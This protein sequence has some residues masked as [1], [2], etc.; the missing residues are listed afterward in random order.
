MEEL[1][2]AATD[3]K[4]PSGRATGWPPVTAS[5]L[6]A[7]VLLTTLWWATGIARGQ[8]TDTPTVPAIATSGDVGLRRLLIGGQV[9]LEKQASHFGRPVVS[10]DGRLLAVTVIP[11]G[12]ETDGLAQVYLFRLSDGGLLAT[13]P[14][15]SPAWQDDSRSLAVENRSGRLVYDIQNGRSIGEPL[16]ERST[17]QST[18]PSLPQ[19]PS[20]PPAYPSHI[21]VMHHPQNNCRNLPA[22]QVDLIPFEEYVARSVP[23]EV[24][25]YW[26]P[27]ALAAQ[28]VAARTYAWYQILQNRPDY[29]V[30]DWADFQMMCDE[31]W[32]ASDQAVA[33]TKGQYLSYQGDSNHRPIIAMYSAMNSHPTLDNPAVPYLRAVPDLTGLGEARWG[34]GFGLSQWGAARRARAGQTYRQILGHYYTGV[35]LQNALSPGDPLGGLLGPTHNGYLPPGG[36]RWRALTPYSAPSS[37]LLISS[38]G[39]LTRTFQVTST[40]SI[41]YTAIITHT[42]GLTETVTLTR[43]A[44]VTETVYRTEPVTLPGSGVWQQPLDLADGTQVAVTLSVSGTVQE[45]VDLRVDRTPPAPPSL[46]VPQSTDMQTVT[47]HTVNPS[48]SQLGLSNHWR[49]E[50]ESLYRSAQG[51][52]VI[53]DT[54][55]SGGSAL[56]VL[57]GRH[58]A[59]SDWYGPYATGLPSGYS[60]RAVFRLRAGQ[61]PARS[62]EGVLP[63]RPIARLDVADKLGNLR[64]GLRDIW[65]SDFAGPDRWQEIGVDFH[66]FEPLQGLEFRVKWYGEVSLALDSVWVWQL[67][68]GEG[69]VSRQ[70]PLA[71]SGA[72]EIQAVAF[73]PALNQ[74]QVVTA[75]VRLVDDG[76]PVFVG[77]N[78]PSGWQ[79]QLPVTLTATVFDRVSGLNSASAGL[80]L[81]EERRPAW[82]DNPTNPWAEQRLIAR[83]ED[84]GSPL[85]DGIY[86]ARFQVA[87]RAG[88]LQYSPDVTLR[89][90]RTPPEMRAFAALTDGQPISSTTGWF[91]ASVDVH[92]DAGDA[93]SGLSSVAYVHNSAPF[94][95]YHKPIPLTA[96]G[97][98]VIRYWAQDIAGNYRYSEYFSAGVDRTPPSVSPRITVS[99][100]GG[101][102][103]N[104]MGLLHWNGADS[105][106]GVAGFRV[107]SR[108]DDG[109]WQPLL[110]VADE[111]HPAGTFPLA[112]EAG[113]V[114]EVRVQAV[115]QVGNSSPWVTVS[116]KQS[117]RL[118]LPAVQRGP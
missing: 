115:D 108:R 16:E 53:S 28:A 9:V 116:S 1:T 109:P 39:G 35:Y 27:D 90:D 111:L 96:E 2:V 8:T 84:G 7:V 41:S 31:R 60:Y 67:Q 37:S 26:A 52:W 3:Q 61:H 103:D 98:H 97:W 58:P 78:G 113:E 50:G 14:G 94:V 93:T 88:T 18:I 87:D 42:S 92:I 102:G 104:G 101:N 110:S 112:W 74:S 85:A 79:T 34:H 11:A 48:G 75:Q 86:Q 114:V 32:P 117:G 19:G 47:L 72:T 106:S 46:S 95:M 99:E 49:W 105:L 76:P 68:S 40:Q 10:P 20:A 80:L 21:R 22:W 43:T 44:T 15:H 63:D 55:A 83:V 62:V 107:E 66:I 29:D 57:P 70:W 45:R 36:L 12:T 5:I 118:F 69:A 13:V 51:G 30:T 100:T 17:R 65:A 25:V 89:L 33:L 73:D 77:V 23:A 64:L 59:N 56:E 71:Q 24:P 54:T 81:G 82:L 38:S 4:M 91:A 6:C